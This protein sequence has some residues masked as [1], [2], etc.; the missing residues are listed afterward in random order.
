[1][2]STNASIG[3]S[4]TVEYLCLIKEWKINKNNLKCTTYL[5]ITHIWHNWNNYPI[6]TLILPC[7]IRYQKIQFHFETIVRLRRRPNRM[8]F[9]PIFAVWCQ[10]HKND[11]Q[12][13]IIYIYYLPS[14]QNSI[15]TYII[16][17]EALWTYYVILTSII[18]FYNNREKVLKSLFSPYQIITFL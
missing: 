10:V 1:M 8:V 2:L 16:H 13:L 5:P 9:S 15:H 12:S 7:K 11:I 3:R 14:K 4:G 18:F 17:S 6:F